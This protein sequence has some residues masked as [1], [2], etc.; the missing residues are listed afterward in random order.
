MAISTGLANYA[1]AFQ[2]SPIVLANGIASNI[3]GGMLPVI[4]IIQAQDFT[5][6]LLGGSNIGLDDYFANFQPLSGSTLI[7]QKVGTYPFANQAV[8]ANATIADPLN[9]SILMLAPASAAGGYQTKL[10]IMSA[11]AA[12]LKQHNASG[13]TYIVATP[14]Q[15]YTG[16]LLLELRDISPAVSK[17]A[18]IGW[19]WD[20]Y[21]PLLTQADA[22]AAQNSL[23]AKISGGAMLQG[24]SPSDWNTQSTTATPSS[25]AAGSISP[26]AASTSAANSASPSGFSGSPL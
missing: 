12:T 8:A 24:Q 23:L 4:S 26:A 17:Q 19:Q 2:K 14:V 18:M 6:G 3:P 25:L 11:L 1:L 21:F 16:G 15:Y 13:G 22:Q 9:V 20:F 10:S 5:F 7:R